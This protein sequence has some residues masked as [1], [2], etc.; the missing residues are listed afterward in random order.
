MFIL[1][2]LGWT[3]GVK[4]R[5]EDIGDLFGSRIR[6][7]AI[8]LVIDLSLNFGYFREIVRILKFVFNRRFVSS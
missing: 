5:D 1:I 4:F 6:I 7:N 3:G 8:K 2:L